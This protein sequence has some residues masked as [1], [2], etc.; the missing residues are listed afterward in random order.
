MPLFFEVWQTGAALIPI[1]H[2]NIY[3]L[4]EKNMKISTAVA[5]FLGYLL[6]LLSFLGC[7]KAGVSNRRPAATFLNCI[8]WYTKYTVIGLLGVPF[9]AI[10]TCAARR[11]AP[12]DNCGP[13]LKMDSPFLGNISSSWKFPFVHLVCDTEFI[14]FIAAARMI[15]LHG[16]FHALWL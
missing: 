8:A 13:L 3:S 11:T 16:T 7:R 10:F 9:V 6:W 15:K 4:Q 1:T 5:D 12:Q 2:L 14:I